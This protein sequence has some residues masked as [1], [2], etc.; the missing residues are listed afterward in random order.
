MSVYIQLTE[1]NWYLLPGATS[2]IDVFFV[3]QDIGFCQPGMVLL[4]N[5]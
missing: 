4:E 3:S 5:R 1:E 2:G